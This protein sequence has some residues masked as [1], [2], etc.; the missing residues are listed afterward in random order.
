M[1]ALL[2]CRERLQNDSAFA[3]YLDGSLGKDV[4]FPQNGVLR[5]RSSITKIKFSCRFQ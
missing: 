3:D 1:V 4:S 2:V 5:N